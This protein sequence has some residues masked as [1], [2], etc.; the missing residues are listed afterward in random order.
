MYYDRSVPFGVDTSLLNIIHDDNVLNTVNT[1]RSL[2]ALISSLFTLK[3]RENESFD[4]FKLR[5][6]LV[7]FLVSRFANWTP[8]INV[9]EQLLSFFTLRG[10]SEQYRISSYL[11]TGRITLTKGFQLLRDVGQSGVNLITSTLGSGT[12]SRP[13]E[14][15]LWY[16]LFVTYFIMVPIV[17]I[18]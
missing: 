6:D 4:T 18:I 3:T 11:A 16:H 7:G 1:T 12:P 9:P 2:F 10:L 15:I 5:F 14:I 8:S 17:L 13:L